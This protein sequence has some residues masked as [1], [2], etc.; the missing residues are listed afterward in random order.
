MNIVLLMPVVL[1]LGGLGLLAMSTVFEKR[2]ARLEKEFAEEL[3]ER[4][5]K[6]SGTVRGTVSPTFLDFELMTTHYSLRA[7]CSSLFWGLSKKEKKSLYGNADSVVIKTGL[8]TS[9]R[10][11]VRDSFSIRLETPVANKEIH[12]R[13]KVS[14]SNVTGYSPDKTIKELMAAGDVVS[15]TIKNQIRVLCELNR[16]A[17]LFKREDGGDKPVPPH[18]VLLRLHDVLFL[19]KKNLIRGFDSRPLPETQED[20]INEILSAIHVL[21]RQNLITS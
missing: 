4:I 15:Q 18:V 20:F 8:D 7:A 6:I 2:N 14:A 16:D 19:G 13:E 9:K 17:L 1:V 10:S 21:D 5:L 11:S 3:A 12:L